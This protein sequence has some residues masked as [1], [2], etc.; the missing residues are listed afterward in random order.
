[1]PQQG[2]EMSN[3]KNPKS[4]HKCQG[5]V[6]ITCKHLADH[7]VQKWHSGVPTERSPLPVAWCSEC[8]ASHVVKGE[9]ETTFAADF[10]AVTLCA[11]SYEAILAKS[12]EG[13]SKGYE[14]VWQ[15]FL[16]SSNAE[17]AKKQDQLI[18]TYLHDIENWKYDEMT[19]RLIFS[20]N[21]IAVVVC[22]VELIGSLS[23]KTNT[24][25]WA[26]ANLHNAVNVRTRIKA[27][28]DFGIDKGFVH[29]TALKWKA[30]EIDAQNMVAI[31]VRVLNAKGF[32][33]M[34]YEHLQ[35]YLAITEIAFANSTQV[36]SR[37]EK[38]S[39]LASLLKRNP[40]SGS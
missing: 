27:V 20:R 38:R 40:K 34:P 16:D 31:A 15:S 9:S 26:W 2:N 14:P 7:P 32:Y 21:G 19:N 37:T 1:M 5:P 29:L 18:S 4:P 36:A 28:A 12:V 23:K 10:P 3:K 22:T 30:D 8:D 13:L 39:L 35:T 33:R 24:W 25:L 6:T 11:A 17:L